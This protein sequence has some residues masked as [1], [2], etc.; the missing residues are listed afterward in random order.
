MRFVLTFFAIMSCSFV[1]GKA[2]ASQSKVK[3]KTQASCYTVNGSRDFCNTGGG[4]ITCRAGYYLRMMDV[5]VFPCGYG[6]GYGARTSGWCCPLP[7]QGVNAE[8]QIET[9][10]SKSSTD[11]NAVDSL[12]NFS[13]TK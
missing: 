7:G 11:V 6:G 10:S 5:A 2:Q 3:T 12:S 13:E 1:N 4:Q 8:E 9:Q